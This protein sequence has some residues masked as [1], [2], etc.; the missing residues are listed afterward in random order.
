MIVYAKS[1]RVINL[2]RCG[3]SNATTVMFDLSDWVASYGAGSVSLFYEVNGSKTIEAVATGSIDESK[4]NFSWLIE[5]AI[6]DEP[7]IGRC[8]LVFKSKDE[9]VQNVS[10]WYDTLVMTSIY[11]DIDYSEDAVDWLDT[12]AALCASLDGRAGSVETAVDEAQQW[13]RGTKGENQ[14]PVSEGEIGYK[15]NSKYYAKLASESQ[16]SAAKSEA[17]LRGLTIKENIVDIG[18]G[19]QC[20]VVKNQDPDTGIE[21]WTFDI[22]VNA[23]FKVAKWYKSKKDMDDDLEGDTVKVGEFASISSDLS[24]PENGKLYV[25][26]EEDSV[27]KWY[28]LCDLSGEQGIRG[29]QGY[30]PVSATISLDGD[31]SFFLNDGDSTV[32]PEIPPTEIKVTGDNFVKW[33]KARKDEIEV[34]KTDTE[35]ARDKARQWAVGNTETAGEPSDTNNSSYYASKSKL[36]AN[37][38]EA[39]AV[40]TVGDTA[41]KEGE[42]GYQNNSLYW[43]EQSA[44]SASVSSL[45]AQNAASS[46][47]ESEAWAI[48]TTDET[49]TQYQN[50]SKWYSEQSKNSS[51]LASQSVTNAKTQADLSSQYA[52]GQKM[53]GTAVTSDEAGY[54]DNA[55]YYKDG[56]NTQRLA[57]EGWAVGAQDGTPVTSGTYYN[58]NAKFYKEKASESANAAA[59]SATAA[60][61]SA[62]SA[63]EYEKEIEGILTQAKTVQS[64]INT[65]K[66]TI[67]ETAKNVETSASDA[68]TSASKAQTAE[69]NAKSAQTQVENEI[70]T[71]KGYKEAAA[72][73]ATEAGTQATNAEASATNASNS[74]DAAAQSQT[75]ANEFSNTSATSATLSQSWAIGPGGDATIVPS[76]VNNSKYWAE[77]AKASYNSI[78]GVKAIA[79]TLAAGSSATAKWEYSSSET[80]LTLGIPTGP[81][82]PKG[83]KGDTGAQGA[84]GASGPQGDQGPKGDTGATGPQGPKGDTGATGSQGEQGIQGEKGEKGDIFVPTVSENGDL[85]WTLETSPSITPSTQN[86]KGPQGDKGDKGDTGEQGLRGEQGETGPKGADGTQITI[87]EANHKVE[88][89]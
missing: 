73:S 55:S 6:T 71:A 26:I 66:T 82:G 3:D 11:Y 12:L 51:D 39:Y 16:T 65:T 56:A 24:D 72:A 27:K 69:S 81:Q 79:N 25:K 67:D 28:F 60:S 43:S 9:K 85:S 22:P 87:D 14:E 77:Q 33:V 2:G 46:A 48:G 41:V 45:Q 40:G 53:D 10:I 61:G 70:T 59:F 76:N 44:E 78:S 75:K 52:R 5:K 63:L 17:Y 34:A 83:D 18:N 47:D 36:S 19:G 49:A 29:P 35:T 38:S 80:T 86:I 30:Y 37:D 31:I 54:N 57:A 89:S 74:A 4:T 88:F 15:D 20:R 1:G 13:A 84:T 21:T 8:Q 68:A 7:G 64:E 58:D 50:N 32:D 62:A 42:R 23:P